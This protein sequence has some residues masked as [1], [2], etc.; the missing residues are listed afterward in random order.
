LS[1]LAAVSTARSTELAF[2]VRIH[3][4]VFNHGPVVR[5]NHEGRNEVPTTTPSSS[6]TPSYPEP[7]VWPLRMRADW[8]DAIHRLVARRYRLFHREP[9][10]RAGLGDRHQL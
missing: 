5:F 3:R 9:H 6:S 7:T 4:V 10:D 1:S 2:A 8:R